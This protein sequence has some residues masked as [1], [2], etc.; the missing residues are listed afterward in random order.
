[1]IVALACQRAPALAASIGVVVLI[2]LACVLI[3][4]LLVFMVRE[5][6]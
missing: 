3:I 1:M 4:A 5:L 6:R 2:S